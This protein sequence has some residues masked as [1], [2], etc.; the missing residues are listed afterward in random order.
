VLHAFLDA[1]LALHA[2]GLRVDEVKRIRCPIAAPLIGIVCEPRAAKIAPEKTWQGRG[3]LPYTLAEALIAGKLDGT[4]YG[5]DEATR[6]AIRALAARIEHEIDPS[7]DPGRFKGWVIVETKDGRVLERV[8]P[9]NRGSAER[10]LS[11]AEIRKKFRDNAAP[12]FAPARIAA[13]EDSVRMLAG[14]GAVRRLMAA[15]SR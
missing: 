8:E 4:S 9:H 13:I 2:E 12:L 6:A 10:P 15:C 14:P 3:S 1:L 11:E 5:G 7:A